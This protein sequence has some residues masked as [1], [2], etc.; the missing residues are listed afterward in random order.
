MSNL[1]KL[2]QDLQDTINDHFENHEAHPQQVAKVLAEMIPSLL[3]HLAWKPQN[4]LAAIAS[5]EETKRHLSM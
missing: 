3:N 2:E 1:N 5:A 4:V